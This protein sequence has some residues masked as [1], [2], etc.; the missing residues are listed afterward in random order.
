MFTLPRNINR[1]FGCYRVGNLMTQLISE[2]KILAEEVVDPE[3]KEKTWFLEGIFMQADVKNNNRRVYPIQVMDKAVEDYL[4]TKVSKG[5]A[6]GELGHAPDPKI[7]LDRVAILVTDLKKNDTDYYG[8]AKVCHEDCPM[9]KVLRGLLKTGGKVG[10]SSRAL[11]S[12]NKGMWQEEECDIVDNFII[13]TI[14]VVADPS[15]PDAMVEAIHEEK[16]YI[17]DDSNGRVLELNE[18]TYK[19]FE[20]QLVSLPK[21]KEKR[22]DKLFESIKHFLDSLRA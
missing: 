17:L 4:N 10:V 19:R 6:W 8:R 5:T 2:D 1:Q 20:S 16:T 7:N 14:D 21:S 12:A 11:G 9:G 13:R 3:S 18:E 22:D 15:A